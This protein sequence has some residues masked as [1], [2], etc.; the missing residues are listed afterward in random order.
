MPNI[1]AMRHKQKILI[2]F[3]L[4]YIYLAN[5]R[6]LNGLE[7]PH[8]RYHLQHLILTVKIGYVKTNFLL[9]KNVFNV[10]LVVVNSEMPVFSLRHYV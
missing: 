2:E 7:I 5:S 9:E 8:S 3:F 10:N 4:K 6:N 1:R